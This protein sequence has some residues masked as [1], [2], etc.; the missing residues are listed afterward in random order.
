MRN[1][2]HSGIQQKGKMGGCHQESASVTVF[3]GRTSVPR[4]QADK[5]KAP[6]YEAG[7]H[8]ILA[9]RNQTRVHLSELGHK[10][11]DGDLRPNYRVRRPRSLCLSLGWVLETGDKLA[12]QGPRGPRAREEGYSRNQKPD[13]S[14]STCTHSHIIRVLL[15]RCRLTLG[16]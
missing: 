14:D 8:G 13:S 15:A 1:L 2:G 12:S 10:A 3:Q 9:P 11:N 4:R 7:Y 16:P 6:G 5:N